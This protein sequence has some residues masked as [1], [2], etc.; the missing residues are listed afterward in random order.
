MSF[1]I[2]HQEG[3]DWCWNAVTTSVEHYFK[4]S[5]PLTQTNLA[6]DELGAP[7]DEPFFLEDALED[8]KLFAGTLGGSLSFRDIQMQLAQNLPVCV[9][10]QWAGSDLSHYVVIT[11]YGMSPGGDA[12]VNVSDPILE[13]GNVIVWDYEAFVFAYSPRYTESEGSWA[14]TILVTSQGG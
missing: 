7:I 12:Q 5:S 2:Q 6:V 13:N 9:Q 4:P 11:G 1:P 8:R 10:I 14:E 3:L